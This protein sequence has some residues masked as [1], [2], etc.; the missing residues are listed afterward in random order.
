[1]QPSIVDFSTIKALDPMRL[2]SKTSEQD[3][4]NKQKASPDLSQD[5]HQDLQQQEPQQ[6]QQSNPP[7]TMKP[8]TRAPRPP[9][10]QRKDPHE[11]P[12]VHSRTMRTGSITP[13]SDS[14]SSD[15]RPG[16]SNS[17]QVRQSAL[18]REYVQSSEEMM[19]RLK[20]DPTAAQLNFRLKLVRRK[21]FVDSLHRWQSEHGLDELD[22]KEADYQSNENSLP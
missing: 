16:S 6:R 1:M 9:K 2:E 21:S 7:Q 4:D 17:G 13:S 11:S 12:Q 3:K 22:A 5:L 20:Q 10:S 19:E 15:S 18:S 8:P 14:G